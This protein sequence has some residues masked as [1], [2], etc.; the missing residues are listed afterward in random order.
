MQRLIAVALL[1][2]MTIGFAVAAEVKGKVK[3]VDGDKLVVTVGKKGDTKDETYVIPASAKILQGKFNK[4]TKKF[5]AGDPVDG[6]LKS[7]KE[8]S[9]VTLEVDGDKVSQVIVGG[10]KKKKTE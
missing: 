9:F 4:D 8:G 2:V 10:G 3:M 5:E 1:F 6:G 7:V